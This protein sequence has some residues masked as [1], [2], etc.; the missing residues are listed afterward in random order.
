[1]RIVIELTEHQA[2]AYTKIADCLMKLG[3]RASCYLFELSERE[4]HHLTGSIHGQVLRK[5][6]A[7][8]EAKAKGVK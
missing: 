4:Y 7:I 8:K 6:Q 2:K 5:L 3:I 1:M